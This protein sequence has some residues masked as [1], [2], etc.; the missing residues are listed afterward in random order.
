MHLANYIT[1]SRIIFII[2]VIYFI[3]D[4]ASTS[5]WLALSLFIVAG[6]TDR[7]D[8]YVARKTGKSSTLGGLLDLIADKLLITITLIY[9]LSFSS[10]HDLIFPALIIIARELIV[11]SLRQFLAENLGSNPIEVS[12]LAKAKTTI[13]ITALSLLIISPNFGENFFLVTVILFWAAAFLSL[14][15]L[16]SYLKLYKNLIK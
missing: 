7:L 13:Q 8:G 16:F 15:T 11:S 14:Y 10:T 3:S 4:Q 12:F 1:I 6:I 5:N 2:P 9:L